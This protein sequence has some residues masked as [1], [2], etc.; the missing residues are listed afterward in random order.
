MSTS[1]YQEG[2]LERNLEVVAVD[3]G[4]YRASCLEGGTNRLFGGQIVALGLRAAAASCEEDRE[5][6]SVHSYFLH[7]GQ[8][9]SAVSYAVTNLKDGRTFSTRRVDALQGDRVICTL[10]ASLH[11]PE[12]SSSHQARM[13]QVAP[14]DTLERYLG[15]PPHTN[16]LLRGCFDL[17]IARQ[18]PEG[19]PGD[20]EPRQETWMRSVDPLGDERAV[21]EAALC[22][23]TDLTLPRTADLPHRHEPGRRRAASL[24]HTLWFHRP[25]RADQWLLFCQR[26]PSYGDGRGMSIG[27]VFAQ[28]GALVASVA[29]ENLI[30]RRP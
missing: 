10:I 23:I 22:W 4:T 27:Q 12:E 13:P 6:H 30:R 28:D 18:L 3:Q 11:V 15:I 1:V 26:S 29:Q 7:P 8:V 14:P 2:F 21:H 16:P 25:F 19:V 9:G 5:V 20:P 17:R 24:D